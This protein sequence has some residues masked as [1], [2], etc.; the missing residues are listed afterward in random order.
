LVLAS[1]SQSVSNQDVHTNVKEKTPET[2]IVGGIQA[3]VIG[4]QATFDSPKPI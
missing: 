1:S 4:E 2:S 3:G